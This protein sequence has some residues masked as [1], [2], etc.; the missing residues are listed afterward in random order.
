M[1]NQL[2]CGCCGGCE[3]ASGGYQYL[4]A[5]DVLSFGNSVD[6]SKL[7][8]QWD[9]AVE[10]RDPSDWTGTDWS[11][12]ADGA[13][14]HT[15]AGWNGSALV[16]KDLSE[17]AIA[18]GSQGWAYPAYRTSEE[19]GEWT[20][21]WRT[22]TDQDVVEVLV[23]GEVVATHSEN[24]VD[25]TFNQ[26]TITVPP[27]TQVRFNL[28]GTAENN[29]AV[30][31]ITVVDWANENHCCY[32]S[33]SMVFSVGTDDYTILI[34]D[35][36]T[37]IPEKT[38]CDGYA[39]Y[40]EQVRTWTV[41]DGTRVFNLWRNTYSRP[42][43]TTSSSIF[44]PIT[45]LVIKLRDGFIEF[46]LLNQNAGG[47]HD[48]LVTRYTQFIP[49]ETEGGAMQLV[50]SRDD[51]R[52]KSW[53]H[54]DIQAE[55]DCDCT[56][57]NTDCEVAY[58]CTTVDPH[59][60]VPYS[61]SLT[62][63]GFPTKPI[64]YRQYSGCSSE[65]VFQDPDETIDL[66]LLY[67]TS[68]TYTKQTF[69]RY[70]AFVGTY[71][72]GSDVT[73]GGC[74]E[75]FPLPG[76]T[77][78]KLH[79][80]TGCEKLCNEYDIGVPVPAYLKTIT[81]FPQQGKYIA[82]CAPGIAKDLIDLNCGCLYEENGED[83][84][85]HLTTYEYDYYKGVCS[86]SSCVTGEFGCQLG[87]CSSLPDGGWCY[88]YV[89]APAQTCQSS[90]F[91]TMN[92]SVTGGQH[93]STTLTSIV[94]EMDD[95]RTLLNPTVTSE[96]WGDRIY[97]PTT[98]QL[99]GGGVWELNSSGS[100]IFQDQHHIPQ[101]SVDPSL[102]ANWSD[103]TDMMV[104]ATQEYYYYVYEGEDWDGVPPLYNGDDFS[105][106]SDG[107]FAPQTTVY[108]VGPSAQ[109]DII[110]NTGTVGCETALLYS[111]NAW[112]EFTAD[113][114]SVIEFD[115]S[116]AGFA[117]SVTLSVDGVQKQNYAGSQETGTSDEIAVTAG[118][119][120]RIGFTTQA[121]GVD[122]GVYVDAIRVRE[123]I[124]Q[125]YK[126]DP[127]GT[128][129]IEVNEEPH[130]WEAP[131]VEYGINGTVFF[132]A[133]TTDAEDYSGP[134]NHAQYCYPDDECDDLPFGGSYPLDPPDFYCGNWYGQ[135]FYD[136]D[137][138]QTGTGGDP[139]EE[140]IGPPSGVRAAPCS[141]PSYVL[142]LDEPDNYPSSGIE[143]FEGYTEHEVGIEFHCWTGSDLYCSNVIK[144]CDGELIG[145]KVS[146]DIR[147][148]EAVGVWDRECKPYQDD[149]NIQW[150]TH[151]AN[152]MWGTW[153]YATAAIRF[154]RKWFDCWSGFNGPQA[155][156]TYADLLDPDM[157]I[158]TTNSMSISTGG[159]DS[160]TG[161][162]LAT[163]TV[164]K[165]NVDLT[166]I[167]L[168]ATAM[169]AHP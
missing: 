7:H 28:T 108:T 140:N 23:D 56:P 75:G 33:D 101:L 88:E 165:S 118:S 98:D 50:N 79:P 18:N 154:R 1:S 41:S 37:E 12:D 121:G 137:G 169:S 135:V 116:F 85:H 112:F 155:Q 95:E 146:C 100:W 38:G 80:W 107:A 43:G 27:N 124:D 114:D 48:D 130:P 2:F 54:V 47:S 4:D 35:V 141:N 58:T 9:N 21:N 72:D 63:P 158:E 126:V 162:P 111:N 45:E 157:E 92:E 139:P 14:V 134:I 103:F 113:K 138:L 66:P 153:G 152:S 78:T 76:D 161:L 5:N 71:F 81:H 53:D 46:G 91:S 39:A 122:L 44:T 164:N 60:H 29:A 11:G 3:I 65:T 10:V 129:P 84:T 32:D 109:T 97:Y 123:P 166:G 110:I 149:I 160:G 64:R 73:G 167:S 125:Q 51:M 106:Y 145:A 62:I 25:G 68:E 16:T 8:I 143:W 57:E 87:I 83:F 115:Y 22:E 19:T 34:K 6:N 70:N 150:A 163:V 42:A 55:C 93:F 133:M 128:V 136:D 15:L 52:I 156:F 36:F 151:D 144:I 40:T 94:S 104:S 96:V 26:N 69:Y 117:Q 13:S 142:T 147:W 59:V 168:T 67:Y 105:S 159:I 127:N 131:T 82:E 148:Q 31:E 119:V 49:Y 17:D 89:Y 99:P 102:A 86:V 30:G 77:C 74:D 90:A 20:Y 120:V 61:H 132:N 24:A